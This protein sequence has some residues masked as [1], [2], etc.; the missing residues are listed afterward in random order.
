MLPL[1]S[2]THPDAAR[3][4]FQGLRSMSRSQRIAM[5]DELT[6]TV[7]SLVFIGLRRRYPELTP[8]ELRSKLAT[9]YLGK[10]LASRLCDLPGADAI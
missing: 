4:Q 10:D 7:R 9:I 8:Q 6:T 5:A 3:A 1:I 2:D